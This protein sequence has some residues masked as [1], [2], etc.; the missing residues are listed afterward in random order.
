MRDYFTPFTRYFFYP[1]Y[2]IKDGS[3]HEIRYLREYEKTQY[4]PSASIEELQWQRLKKILIHAD[5]TCPFYNKRFAGSGFNP[6]KMSSFSDLERIPILT[7][8]DVQENFP[9]M[10]SQ[11]YYEK[12]LVKDKSG[13]STGGPVV[14]YYNRERLDSRQAAGLRHDRWAGWDIGNRIAIIWG[15]HSDL[16]GYQRWKEKVR[17]KLL[18]RMLILDSSAMTEETMAG[19]TAKLKKYRP[20]MLLVY[21]NSLVLYTRYLQSQGISDIKTESIITTCEVLTPED[22]KLLEDY[23]ECEIFDRYGSRELDIIASECDQHDGMHVNAE[24]LYLEFVKDGKS[25]EPGQL[26]EILITDLLNYGMPLIRYQIGDMGTPMNGSCAC[27]RGLPRM[28]NLAGRVTDFI[29]TPE[30]KTVSG[31]AL[32]TYMITN[33]PGVSQVQLI[34]EV[35]D[36]LTVKLIRNSLFSEDTLKA[37]RANA[38]KFLGTTIQVDF[39]FVDHIPKTPSG[40]SLFSISKVSPEIW[41]T[42]D[43]AY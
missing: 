15:A 21:T 18:T 37:L 20:K 35:R 43:Q 30:N 19:F 2:K 13:G 22:R 38:A 26:G 12:P 40:K 25:V 14:L 41:N 42:A 11:E 5:K 31:V 4:M 23:W 3:Y 29:T 24:N 9:E 33:I 6:S 32:A 28:Q 1:F 7:R 34:Q 39:D 16:Q 8:R 17:N 10:I 27:G 36:R